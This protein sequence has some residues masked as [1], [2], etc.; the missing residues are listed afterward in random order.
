MAD[1][2]PDT[3]SFQEL[4]QERDAYLQTF[5][6]RRK[7]LDDRLIDQ[8]TRRKAFEESLSEEISESRAALAAVAPISP[9]EVADIPMR[10]AA[11][12]DR[13]AAVMAKLSL[14]AYVAFEDEARR[15]VLDTALSASGL[16]L[17]KHWAVGSTEVFMTEAENFVAVS[18]RGTTDRRDRKTDFRITVGQVQ[19]QGHEQSVKV[20]EGFYD[21]FRLVEPLVHDALVET[22]PSKPIFLT[23]HSLG[24]ALALIAS[25]AFSGRDVLGG[26]IA[27]VYTFGAPRVGGDGFAR[28]VKAPHYRIV[29]EG[30]VVPQVPPN[31][32]SGYRHTGELYL[33]RKGRIRAVRTRPW[34]STVLLALRGLIAWPFSKEL[35]FARR[36]AISL[37]ASRLDVIAQLRGRWS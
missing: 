11:Y 4:F 22:D 8:Q 20:H 23:G 19:V 31:W 12:T 17:T 37:Y 7:A 18:F 30:D 21:A 34:L 24:G 15:V 9:A 1:E 14:L 10:R 27:A 33:L 32:L 26:R 35:L 5:E 6:S 13:M 2:T 29:N 16:K 28:V 25:A 36:H 3:R